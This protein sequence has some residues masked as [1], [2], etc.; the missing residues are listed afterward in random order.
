MKYLYLLSLLFIT[1]CATISFDALEYD[2]FI[3]I[4][5]KAISMKQL[6][7]TPDIQLAITQLKQD[8]DHQYTY[9][10]YR[11]I[12]PIIADASKNLKDIIDNFYLTSKDKPTSMIYCTQK[13]DNI[14]IGSQLLIKELGKF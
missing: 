11:A 4:Q 3:S 6:C 5:E 13:L 1:S 9:E 7:G 10:M 14:S 12:K 8:M 2:R